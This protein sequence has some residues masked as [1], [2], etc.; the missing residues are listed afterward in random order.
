V[1]FVAVD[2]GLARVGLAVSDPGERLA[3]PLTTLHFKNFADR[4]A[5]LNALADIIIAGKAEGVVI[6]LPL[7]VT[8][9]GNNAITLTTRQVYNIAIRLKRRL[10]LPLFFMSEFLSTHEALA[11]LRQARLV[12]HRRK[13]VLDQQAAVRILLSFL[14]LAPDE[15]MSA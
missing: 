7:L 13:A 12:P 3:F 8:D 1:K 6:G 15:R 5:L 9:N 11:D 14:A 2:Y 4:K 10:G